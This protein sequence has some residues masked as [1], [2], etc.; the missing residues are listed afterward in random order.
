MATVNHRKERHIP[1]HTMTLDS[2]L[3]E[4]GGQ[5][6]SAA[7]LDSNQV[8]LQQRETRQLGLD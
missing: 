4:P 5:V 3:R 6:R 2:F 1:P 7:Q 8:E